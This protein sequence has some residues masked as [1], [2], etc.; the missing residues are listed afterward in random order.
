MNPSINIFGRTIHMYGILCSLGIIFSLIILYILAKKQKFEFFDFS[1]VVVITLLSAFVGSKLLFV[2]VSMES[3]ISIFKT[4]SFFNALI[5]IMQG[6]F[7][8]YGGLIGGAVGLLIITKIRKENM[9]KYSNL[10]TLVLPLG[11][12]FGRVG[13]FLSGCCYGMKHDGLFSFTYSSALDISTPIGVPLLAI[14]LIEAVCLFTL[15]I[16]LLVIYYKLPEKRNLITWFYLIAYAI[17][18]FV[19]EFFRGD[20]ERGLFLGLSTSQWLSCLIIIGV[21]IYFMLRKIKTK[22]F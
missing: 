13:C 10:F 4:F 22:K 3:I 19:L 7:V 5:G 18:R 6:G 16:A 2:I 15:F 17:I 21:S 11:H 8:F 20:K 1:L 14:Q 9:F 12:A